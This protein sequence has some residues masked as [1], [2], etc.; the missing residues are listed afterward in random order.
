MQIQNH[1][2]LDARFVNSP[3]YNE[4]PP[5]LAPELIVVHCISLPPGSFGGPQIEQ[6]FQNCLCPNEHPYFAEV[7]QLKVSAHLLIRRDGELVQFVPFDKRA[8]HAGQSCHQGRDNCN[9]FS[10]GI[11]LEGT[12]DSPY[13]IPQY[14][15]LIRV[16]DTL[17]HYYPSL[18]PLQVVGHS[19][20]APDRKADPGP[21]FDW[22]ILQQALGLS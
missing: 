6:L 7:H 11:E 3:N 2:L 13:E 20:I 4:R 9:D 18:N 8:W 21:G 12:E 5:G 15:Q 19:D 17:R 22:T 14:Q 1:R 10:I 16:I